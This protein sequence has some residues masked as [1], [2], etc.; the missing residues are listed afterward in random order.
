MMVIYAKENYTQS[1]KLALQAETSE[2]KQVSY[3]LSMLF[4]MLKN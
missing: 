3:I 2:V 4:S 1:A